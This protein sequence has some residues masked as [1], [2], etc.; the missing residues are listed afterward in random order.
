MYGMGAEQ[1]LPD[2]VENSDAWFA[3]YQAHPNHWAIELEGKCIGATR[4]SR[5]DRINRSARFSIGVFDSSQWNKGIG[6]EAT[7]LVVAYAFEALKMHRIELYVLEFNKRA[8]S[9]YK[10]CGF[11]I[12][13][14]AR[15][16][17]LVGQTWQSEIVMSI[18]EEEYRR[19]G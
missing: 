15:D 2:S 11:R 9:C 14:K 1:M 19:R 4:L 12:E 10:K 18:L 13:G 5:I 16:S 6:T 7:S 17:V 3:T 8:L